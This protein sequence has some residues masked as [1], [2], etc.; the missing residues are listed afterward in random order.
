MRAAISSIGENLKWNWGNIPFETFEGSFE[1]HKFL[2]GMEKK[3]FLFSSLWL[4]FGSIHGWNLL[5]Q[6]FFCSIMFIDSGSILLNNISNYDKLSP[7]EKG[8]KR[9]RE[10][11]ENFFP[12]HYFPFISSRRESS[13][14]ERQKQRRKKYEKEINDEKRSKQWKA[15]FYSTA[16]QLRATIFSQVT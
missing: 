9:E 10:R 11:N 5:W 1:A 3:M 2:S 15:I 12:S 7:A 4:F 14:V 8:K 16:T 6:F 13:R